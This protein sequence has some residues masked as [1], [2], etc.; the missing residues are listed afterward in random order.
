VFV[1]N[2]TKQFQPP[3]SDL[4]AIDG[5]GPCAPY[6]D[7]SVWPRCAASI[8]RGAFRWTCQASLI[9]A[10]PDATVVGRLDHP[11]QIADG[12]NAVVLD[13]IMGCLDVPLAEIKLDS[14]IRNVQ[15]EESTGAMRRAD[16]T[17]ITAPRDAI[18][19]PDA[20]NT[21]GVKVKFH[22]PF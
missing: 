13:Q 6:S 19:R 20:D 11:A 10:L 15:G 17:E 7:E 14:G 9:E 18:R 22:F 2:D 8:Y 5:I 4:V 12:N 16:E 1:C 3:Q 21:D